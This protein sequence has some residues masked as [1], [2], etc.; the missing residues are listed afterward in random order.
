MVCCIIHVHES[1]IHVTDACI[2]DMDTEGSELIKKLAEMAPELAKMLVQV[3]QLA[4]ALGPAGAALSM[5]VDLLVMFHAQPDSTMRKKLDEIS[6]HVKS[7]QETTRIQLNVLEAMERFLPIYDKILAHVLRLEQIFANPGN[8]ESFCERLGGMTKDYSP[9]QII[10]DLC[11]MHA[12]IMGKTGFGKPL[13]EQL[14]EE[15]YSWEGEEFDTFI[16]TFLLQFHTVVSLEIR[17]VRMLRSFVVYEQKDTIFDQDI[18]LILTH[19]A[20]Q[21]KEHDPAPQFEWY[22]KF[23][24][25]GGEARL[26]IGKSPVSYMYMEDSIFSSGIKI[27]AEGTFSDHDQSVFIFSPQ[28]NGTFRMTSKNG[29]IGHVL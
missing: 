7:L 3:G 1:A 23:R 19:L 5:G 11:Q 20:L 12:L 13:F 9:N 27:G 10:V 15:A 28:S 17:A 29:K 21:Y 26:S 25:S 18:K 4:S 8:S 6:H 14:A 22:F 16:G 2:T 24:A